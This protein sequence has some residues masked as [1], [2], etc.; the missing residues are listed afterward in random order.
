MN[1]GGTTRA[2]FLGA[3]DEMRCGV[4]HFT[5][6]LQAALEKLRPGDNETLTLTQSQGSI[7]DIWR[8]VGST[9]AVICNF[10]IVAWKRVILRPLLALAMA[11]LRGRR[12]VLIQHEWAS[13]NWMRRLTYLPAVVLA[14]RIIMFSPLVRQELADDGAV[15]PTARKS[16]LAPLPP[17]VEAP[18]GI[19]E[20]KLQRRL[21]AA[22]A[23]GRLIVGHFGS[24]YPAKQPNALLDIAAI[25]KQRGLK[26]LVV[27]IGSFIRGTDNVEADFMARVAALGLKDDVAVSG[28]IASDH[29]VFGSFR[30]VDVFCYP[31]TEGLTA[32]RSSIL[33]CAQAGKPLIV[34]GPRRP[35]E[36]DHHPR[37]KRL[38]EQGGIVLMPRDAA[39]ESYAD[40][41]VAARE[42]PAILAPFDFDGWWRD[43]AEAVAAQLES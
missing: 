37:F 33:A 23:E 41:I 4:G 10:P 1:P 20:S 11:R 18:A 21:A 5:R 17:N 43:V 9:D 36:F 39:N 13:L 12:V 7:V 2:L 32:R 15:G 27:Y 34:T 16:V 25:L 3:G 30:E 40:S 31:L 6:L 28:Y 22:K 19:A 38:I 26:P 35:D 8:A 42:R 14:H 29:E 24:I